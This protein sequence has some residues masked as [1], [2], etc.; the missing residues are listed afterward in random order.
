LNKIN[1]PYLGFGDKKAIED[2]IVK[3]FLNSTN[4]AL[5]SDQE[6]KANPE[7]FVK[8]NFEKLMNRTPNEFEIWFLVE[9]INKNP[10]ITTVEFYYSIMTSDEYRYY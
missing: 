6:M 8:T 4:N 9:Y 5:P 3:N 2:L 1:T 7:L 10:N